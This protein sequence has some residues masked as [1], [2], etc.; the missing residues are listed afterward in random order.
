LPH[1]DCDGSPDDHDSATYDHRPADDNHDQCAH[2]DHRTA[3]NHDHGANHD[4]RTADDD[5]PTVRRR[6]SDIDDNGNGA[7]TDDDSFPDTHGTTGVSR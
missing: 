2:H 3:D 5:D 7:P 4:H 6:L 1:N